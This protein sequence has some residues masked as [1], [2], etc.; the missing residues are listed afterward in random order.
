MNFLD[1]GFAIKVLFLVSN[2]LWLLYS[3]SYS[4]VL[5]LS[6][7]SFVTDLAFCLFEL[8]ERYDYFLIL[9]GLFVE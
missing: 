7:Y 9:N 8:L 6:L 1:S 4:L 3:L 5:D 2:L